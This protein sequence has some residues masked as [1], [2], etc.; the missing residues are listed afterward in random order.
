MIMARVKV[1]FEI[2]LPVKGASL[3]DI[4]EW[5]EYELGYRG[6]MSMN[7]VLEPYDIENSES[8]IVESI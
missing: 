7:N 6:G 4:V 1:S 8:V 2:E 5:I 3:E